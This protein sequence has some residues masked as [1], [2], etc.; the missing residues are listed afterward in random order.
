[1]KYVRESI[2]YLQEATN[3]NYY[4][5]YIAA[6]MQLLHYLEITYVRFNLI[7]FQKWTLIKIRKTLKLYEI[8]FKYFQYLPFHRFLLM[9]VSLLKSNDFIRTMNYDHV[10]ITN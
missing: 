4:H 8:I 7:N 2:L 9:S 1:M 10:L 6:R 3:H 5:Y